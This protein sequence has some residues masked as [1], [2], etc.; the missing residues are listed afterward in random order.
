MTSVLPYMCKGGR[1]VRLGPFT[2]G[3][4]AGYRDEELLEIIGLNPAG[5]LGVIACL[6]RSTQKF[7]IQVAGV[8]ISYGDTV[9]ARLM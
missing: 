2:V 1:L 4:R 6:I 8:P 9:V 3:Q 7:S 5:K